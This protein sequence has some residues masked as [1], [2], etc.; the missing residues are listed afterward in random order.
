VIDWSYNFVI[1][2]LSRLYI[3]FY[4][5]Y[6]EIM[7]LWLKRGRVYTI[8]DLEG[9]AY[10]GDNSL[11]VKCFAQKLRKG[12]KPLQVDGRTPDGK[13]PLMCCFEGLLRADA[14]EAAKKLLEPVAESKSEAVIKGA[15]TGIMG[16]AKFLG[17]VQDPIQRCERSERKKELAVAGAPSRERK[18]A[19]GSGALRPTPVTFARAG[20]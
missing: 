13:T 18:R 7:R 4:A 8:E 15:K 11:V 17:V 9:G 10:D 12:A 20:R 2:K 19:S 1:Q 6:M 16:M 3:F 14:E 5:I